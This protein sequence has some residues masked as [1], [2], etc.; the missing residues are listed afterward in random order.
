MKNKGRFQNGLVPSGLGILVTAGLLP[1][2]TARASDRENFQTSTVDGIDPDVNISRSIFTRTSVLW[3]NP[4]WQEFKRLW[5]KLD[6]IG[7]PDGDYSASSLDYE[8]YEKLRVELDNSYIELMSISEEIGIDSIDIRLLH[9]LAS[10]RLDMLSYGT[11]MPFTRMMP[12]PVS[13]Q[14]NDLLSQIE[15]RIDIIAGLREEGLV[16]S[17]EMITAFGNLRFSLDTYFLLETISS[18]THYSGVLWTV[19][20][21]LEADRIQPH[22]DS[23]KAAAMNSLQD[24]EAEDDSELNSVLLEDLESMEQSLSDTQDRLPALHDLLLDL[25]L[26]NF[27]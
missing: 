27:R 26:F 14:T 20:W 16:S 8:E 13:D 6:S 25:E 7:P 3:S 4:Q 1:V 18:R 15:A 21:P 11:R 23:I 19:T 22:L 12:P 10:D 24:T 5:R 2:D 9:R 17:A